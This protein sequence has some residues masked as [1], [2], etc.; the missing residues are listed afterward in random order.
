M[1]RYRMGQEATVPF[2]FITCFTREFLVHVD[3]NTPYYKIAMLTWTWV[4]KRWCSSTKLH[5]NE[6]ASSHRYIKCKHIGRYNI[7]SF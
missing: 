7:Y 6:T 2:G 5:F 1:M 4:D 3:K